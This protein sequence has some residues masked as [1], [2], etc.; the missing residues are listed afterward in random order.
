[1]NARAK[2]MFLLVAALTTAGAFTS[3]QLALAGGDSKKNEI[4]FTDEFFL[5]D[6]DFSSTGS[7]RFFILEPDYRLVF[8][9]EGDR[10]EDVELII[11]V[12]DET[13]VVDGI[14]TR[15]VE[16]RESVDGE[17]VEVS[18]NYF[19][20]CKQTN[21]AFYFGE[22]VD[23]YE[24]GQIVSHEGA[25][26]AGQEGAEAGLAMPG[27]VLLGSKYQQEIAPGIAMDRARIVSM[28]EEVDTAAGEFE[29]VLKIAETTP[30]EPGVVEYKYYAAEV[31]LIQDGD[32][33]LEEY[34]FI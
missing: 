27:I 6:C 20:I 30:L 5:E 7:N 13:K 12:L 22:D 29:D 25:W 24:G 18:R 4:G 17:L 21:S 15:V 8:G 32:L 28:D 2:R 9:G 1:M 23:I 31:G 19:A 33:K 3:G 11:T 14:K 26:L 10:G 34:G 16:E